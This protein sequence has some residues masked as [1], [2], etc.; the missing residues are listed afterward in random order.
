VRTAW[1]VRERKVRSG[2]RRRVRADERTLP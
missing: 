2:Q 1:A